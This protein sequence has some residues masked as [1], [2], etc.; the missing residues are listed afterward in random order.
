MNAIII[1]ILQMIV[2]M[3][4]Y[5]F[6]N[7]KMIIGM[8]L[9]CSNIFVLIIV[10]L[11]FP[12]IKL[13]WLC[14]LLIDKEKILVL[15]LVLCILIIVFW[16]TNF[17][18]LNFINHL[19]FLQYFLFAICIIMICS[20]VVKMGKYKI[21][22]KEVE[23]ELKMHRL[24][25][26][27]FDN[28]ID[29]IRS[30]QHEFDNHINVIYSQHYIYGTYDELV[31]A[32]KDYCQVVTNENKFN[33][34]LNSGNRIIIGFLYGKFVEI[35]RLGINISYH[36]SIKELDVGIPIYKL[37][38]I[39]GNLIENA[40]EAMLNLPK[41]RKLYIWM[42]E[43]DNGEFGI[44]IRN[45]SDYVSYSE[46]GLFFTKGYSRKGENR[47]LGLYHVKTICDEYKLTL[48]CQN[49]EI[50]GIN[51]ISFYISNKKETT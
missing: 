31:E 21:K 25:A 47:G 13:T 34:M 29:N 49:K 23:T 30:R 40:I 15:A 1:S 14:N 7:Q 10:T 45:E 44:E 24:Y 20:L 48:L 42:E 4:L 12:K 6:D 51:W 28:L 11:I 35:D 17:K 41:Y 36:I 39:I 18:N 9:L 27:S 32:Q 26:N 3:L 50:D 38:E 43:D 2:M 5:M 16:L 22:S 19:E 33:K 37:V 46:I 8:R